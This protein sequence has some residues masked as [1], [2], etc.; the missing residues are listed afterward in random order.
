M[1]VLLTLPRRLFSYWSVLNEVPADKV[2]WG[3]SPMNDRLAAVF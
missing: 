2:P 1:R 3:R